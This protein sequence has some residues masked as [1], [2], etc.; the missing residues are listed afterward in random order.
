MRGF[1]ARTNPLIK[2]D[3]RPGTAFIRQGD[4]EFSRSSIKQAL[5]S[6]LPFIMNQ[7]SHAIRLSS[8]DDLITQS[9]AKK[10]FEVFI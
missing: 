1:T 9:S 8:T 3:V 4:Q 10:G 2:T 6:I 7:P 5:N